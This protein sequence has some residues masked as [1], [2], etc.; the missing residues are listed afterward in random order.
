MIDLVDSI[1]KRICS[2]AN[3][4]SCEIGCSTLLRLWDV[5]DYTDIAC[6]ATESLLCE[7]TIHA[8]F[9]SNETKMSAKHSDH[10]TYLRSFHLISR[11]KRET[12]FTFLDVQH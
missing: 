12:I 2:R 9:D 1:Y 6:V 7:D 3:V 11:T 10:A 4:C 8:S 5:I